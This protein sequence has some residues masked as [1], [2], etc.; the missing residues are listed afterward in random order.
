MRSVLLLLLCCL[1]FC[2]NYIGVSNCY[3]VSRA[4]D[5]QDCI[6]TKTIKISVVVLTTQ[7]CITRSCKVLLP[8]HSLH[9]GWWDTERWT[10]K[11]YILFSSNESIQKDHNAFVFIWLLIKLIYP[12]L[13]WVCG[14][15]DWPSSNSRTL[16]QHIQ[17]SRDQRSPYSIFK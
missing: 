8:L 12:D 3:N 10:V 2:F 15:L 1:G 14:S 11:L 4:Q 7:D 5:N 9:L 17:M 16:N 6:T 13:L